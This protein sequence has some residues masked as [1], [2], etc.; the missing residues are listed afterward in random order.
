MTRARP[1]AGYTL[2]ELLIT[3]VIGASILA[4]SMT[5][6]VQAIRANAS[7]AD[8]ARTVNNLGRLAEQFRADVHDSRTFVSEPAA[9]GRPA[10]L[11][12]TSDDGSHVGYVLSADELTRTRTIGDR[13]VQR[14]VYRLATLRAE[15]FRA[16]QAGGEAA[17]VLRRTTNTPSGDVALGKF[18]IVAV[19]PRAGRLA[20]DAAKVEGQP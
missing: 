18:E 3:I 12:L 2:I 17:I 20:R 1:H 8:H 19:A 9:E 16:D 4:A 7:A 15:S 13:M 6:L 10:Q 5:L 11:T 14:D